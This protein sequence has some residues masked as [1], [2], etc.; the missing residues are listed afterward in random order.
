MFRIFN[1]NKIHLLGLNKKWVP[2]REF[3]H[4]KEILND[5]GFKISNSKFAFGSKVYLHDKYSLRKS[6]YHLFRN[7][8][9]FDYFHGDPEMN[10]E[11]ADLF[12]YIICN[13]NK[14]YKIRVT[15]DITFKMFSKHGL[16][17][18]L[19]KIYLGVDNKI[20]NEITISDKK[21]IKQNLNIPEDHIVI[22]SFQKD[23][24]GW[25]EGLKPK[26][27]KG[28]DIFIETIKLLKQ[29]KTKI[30]VLLLGPAR[31]FIKKKLEKLNINFLHIYEKD[32][33]SIKSYYNI[34][35]FYLICSREEGG[36]KSLLES[37]A[38][39]VP[40]VTTPVG[41]SVELVE[42]K[43]NGL[44]INNF[45]PNLLA[46]KSLELIEDKNLQINIKLAGKQTALENDYENQVSLWKDFF[47]D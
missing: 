10:P 26:L 19:K 16:K 44:I 29:K 2:G 24:E 17:E 38:C 1:K 25:G 35:D 21:K 27:I 9:Y 28:P 6:F 15:N 22:G 46:E 30:F 7:K 23:G 45:S 18:K 32:Y 4:L 5:K 11:F 42:N 39:G 34:L 8:V 13:Q 31:G 14:F 40:I 36:P 41:Q 37:M 47:N 20:F 33:L 12:E 3:H 43:K